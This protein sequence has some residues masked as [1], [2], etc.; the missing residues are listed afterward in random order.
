MKVVNINKLNK[1]ERKSVRNNISIANEV[2]DKSV[3]RTLKYKKKMLFSAPHINLVSQ[4]IYCCS[5]QHVCFSE[6]GTK[7]LADRICPDQARYQKAVDS[8]KKTKEL[9]DRIC[10]DEA[11]RPS[12]AVEAVKNIHKRRK[13]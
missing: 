7:E 9:A 13:H 10:P 1:I 12:E 6:G 5:V 2:S 11:R 8:L 3:K 4:K